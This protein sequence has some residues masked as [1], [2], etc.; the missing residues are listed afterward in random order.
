MEFKQL[1]KE[2]SEDKNIYAKVIWLDDEGKYCN[3][4]KNKEIDY[5]F[6]IV[7]DLSGKKTKL[8]AKKR[9]E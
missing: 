4:D 7:S 5:F 3:C 9:A 6:N 2:A 8:L 1:W